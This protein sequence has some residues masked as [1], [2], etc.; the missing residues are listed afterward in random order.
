VGL[1]RQGDTGCAAASL[2][3]DAISDIHDTRS[4]QIRDIGTIN[5]LITRESRRLSHPVPVQINHHVDIHSG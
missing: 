5:A 1:G 4:V 2:R 3:Q